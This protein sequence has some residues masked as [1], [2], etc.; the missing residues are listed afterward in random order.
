MKFVDS[1]T[2]TVTSG[3]GGDGLASFR[4]ERNIPLGGPDGG[5]GGRGGSVIL[6]ASENVDTLLALARTGKY[7][8]ADGE[9]GRAVC[10]H[11]ANAADLT[12]EVPVGTLIAD[13][14]EI[15]ADLTA[16]G[17]EAIVARGGDGGFGNRRYAAAL[18]QAPDEFTY[19]G[20]SETRKLH[21]E[22]KLIADVGLIGFPNA[23]KSTLLGRLSAARP[24]I[25]D[26]PFTTMQPQ[27]GIVENGAGRELILADIPGLIEGAAAGRGLG[28]EFLRHVERCR[29]LIHLVNLYP[30]DGT[31]PWDNFHAIN[32]ELA[33]FSEK[34]ARTPQIVA[35]N[36]MDL[37]GA[38]DAL[39]LLRAEIGLPVLGISAATGAGLKELKREMFKTN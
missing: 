15:L 14:G 26:Y 24:K 19:G 38:D 12:I 2:V 6:R 35:G 13:G 4:H 18:N 5:D 29:V 8:A 30:L 36:K 27:L 23:G 33:A 34:L 37:T 32:R 9:A 39:E 3:K 21:L 20:E 25:A 1:T 17:Q 22:L 31:Y 7:K 11:G 10:R 16:H 28:H